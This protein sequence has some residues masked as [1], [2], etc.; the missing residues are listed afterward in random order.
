MPV[1]H[2]ARALS[3]AAARARAHF[4]ALRRLSTARPASPEPNSSKVAGSGTGP[5]MGPPCGPDPLLENQF[6][7]LVL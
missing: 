4:L 3:G 5:S 1:G 2:T 7:S 6:D